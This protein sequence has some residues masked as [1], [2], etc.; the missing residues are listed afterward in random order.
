[1]ERPE[2]R[3]AE[4]AEE[5]VGERA[6]GKAVAAARVVALAGEGHREDERNEDGGVADEHDGDPGPHDEAEHS[7]EAPAERLRRPLARVRGPPTAW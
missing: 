4:D 7:H 1:M 5:G 3:V 6:A 2:E